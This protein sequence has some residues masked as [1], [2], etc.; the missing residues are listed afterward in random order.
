MKARHFFV[1]ATGLFLAGCGATEEAAPPQGPGDVSVDEPASGG[2]GAQAPWFSAAGEGTARPDLPDTN[3]SKPSLSVSPALGTLESLVTLTGSG[4]QRNEKVLFTAEGQPVGSTQADNWGQFSVS[5]P[6]RLAARPGTYVIRAESASHTVAE[7]TFLLVADIHPTVAVYPGRGPA[8]SAVTLVGQGFEPE[9]TV[10]I[11]VGNFVVGGAATDVSGNFS[12]AGQVPSQASPGVYLLH[13]ETSSLVSAD[14]AFEVTPSY[15]PHVFAVPPQGA[16][17][18]RVTLVGSGF[19]PNAPAVVS[20]PSLNNAFLLGTV[21]D[22]NGSFVAVGQVPQVPAAGTFLL[23]V[24]T[25][26]G[27]FAELYFEVLD[28]EPTSLALSVVSGPV[29]APVL[30]MGWNFDPNSEVT[31]TAEGVGIATGQS[32]S[33]GGFAIT[34]AVPQGASPGVHLIRAETAGG[35]F[36]EVPFLVTAGSSGQIQ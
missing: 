15:H 18:S 33:T 12:V 19:E 34:A 8:G 2:E 3:L 6:I 26:L 27:V 32:D 4:F 7:A 17:G 35:R 5:G 13:A 25:S 24:T 9:K 28:S 16:V 30:L 14:V 31:V 22:A 36:A 10:T 21:T 29:G 1:L 23:R 20:V 11:R